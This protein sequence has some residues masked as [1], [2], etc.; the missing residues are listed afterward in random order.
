MCLNLKY[1]LK[2][3]L[4][5]L[6]GDF[7]TNRYKLCIELLISDKTLGR[8]MNFTKDEGKRIPEDKLYLVAYFLGC[9]PDDL[10]NYE[11]SPAC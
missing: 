6:P 5:K 9:N 3:R 2:K 7:V 4:L 1:N 10:V 11:N 8:W